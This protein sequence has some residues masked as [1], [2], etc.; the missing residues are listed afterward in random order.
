MRIVLIASMALIGIPCVACSG[1]GTGDG[2]LPD[3]PVSGSVTGSQIPH[4]AK[5][6][7]IWSVTSG[8]PDYAYKFG[9]GA[10]RDAKFSVNFDGQIPAEAINSYGVGVGLIALVPPATTLPDGKLDGAHDGN[11][12]SK[13]LTPLGITS[14]Y[15]II[16]K[17]DTAKDFKWSTSF[18]AGLSCGVCV[19]APE[20]EVFDSF[21]PID[22]DKLKIETASDPTSI[23]SCNWT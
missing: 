13:E 10:S 8:S 7:V 2:A 9:E 12:S 3:G 14:Q 16:Y 11:P 5:A 23:H 4:E 15:A 21:E 19:P 1:D 20:G 22:C 17:T 18:P 6:V